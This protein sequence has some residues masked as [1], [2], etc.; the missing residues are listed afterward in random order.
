M[1]APPQRAKARRSARSARRNRS[2][3]RAR[4]ARKSGISWRPAREAIRGASARKRIAQ[5][6]RSRFGASDASDASG[7][8]DASGQGCGVR[9]PSVDDENLARHEVGLDEVADGPGDVGGRAR[10]AERDLPLR[11]L[12]VRRS[13]LILGRTP[14]DLGLPLE[15]DAQ[16][17]RTACFLQGMPSSSEAAEWRTSGPSRRS[18]RLPS[19]GS[20]HLD[21]EGHPG[22]QRPLGEDLAGVANSSGGA[23]GTPVRSPVDSPIASKRIPYSATHEC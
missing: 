12:S 6:G 2:P 11:R 14:A 4:G 20:F 8:S 19:P 15:A 23:G 1:P 9:E 13:A 16:S 17:S 22:A 18:S 5:R 10:A 3:L 7:T 21:L